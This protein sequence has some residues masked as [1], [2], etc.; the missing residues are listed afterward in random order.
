MKLLL[1]KNESKL[2]KTRANIEFRI[3]C[4]IPTIYEAYLYRVSLYDKDK[5]LGFYIGYHT[6]KFVIGK[7]YHSSVSKKEKCVKFRKLCRDESIKMI[8]EIIDFGSTTRMTVEESELLKEADPK[9][10]DEC[11]NDSLGSPQYSRTDNDKVF[12]LRDKILNNSN[13]EVK[14]V[15]AKILYDKYFIYLKQSY[16]KYL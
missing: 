3:S 5:F 7:Y 10:N 14:S 16:K 4:D 15:V 8:Y 9:N 2:I 11:F 6:G 1:T 12:A 13:Y